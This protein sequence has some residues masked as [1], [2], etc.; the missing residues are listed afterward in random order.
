MYLDQLFSREFQNLALDLLEECYKKDEKTALK[1]ITG[2][3]EQ[4]NDL[5]CLDV[6]VKSGQLQFVSHSAV[7]SLLNDVWTGSIKNVDISTAEFLLSVVFPP[8][9]YSFD[10]RTES[11]M[12]DMI[13]TE[14]QPATTLAPALPI[15]GMQHGGIQMS[16]L[17]RKEENA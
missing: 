7:Q 2:K 17:E 10:F 1:L 8:Y 13:T 3:S 9:L 11:E 5:T 6:A 15:L 14:E 4:F 12:K 16:D